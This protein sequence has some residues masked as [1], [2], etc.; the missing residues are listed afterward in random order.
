M[1][2]MQMGGINILSFATYLSSSFRGKTLRHQF[3]MKEMLKTSLHGTKPLI[4]EIFIYTFI[5]EI[6]G[7]IVLFFITT[8][9]IFI[10]N[11][12]LIMCFFLFFIPYRLSTM[13]DFP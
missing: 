7:A 5:I 8:I 13:R 12:F 11:H 9:I 10:T 2:L 6:I 1:L 4:K 3:V